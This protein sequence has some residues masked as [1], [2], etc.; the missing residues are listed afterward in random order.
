VISFT[1]LTNLDESIT[2]FAEEVET[3]TRFI[4]ESADRV[5]IAAA[6]PNRNWHT[7]RLKTYEIIGER[8]FYISPKSIRD[9]EKYED[10]LAHLKRDGEKANRTSGNRWTTDELDM[11]E[12]LLAQRAT[13]LEISAALPYRSWQAIRRRIILLRGPGFVIAESGR[14]E[15]G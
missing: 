10:Y 2:W 7:I 8:N 13:Q 5:T 11:P 15:D 3:L 1:L 4:D 6:L 12:E 9:E 14:L